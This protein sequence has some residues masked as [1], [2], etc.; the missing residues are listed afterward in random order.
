[1]TSVSTVSRGATE[2]RERIGHDV[3]EGMP[4]APE[5]RTTLLESRQPATE[6][7]M[8]LNPP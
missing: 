8:W 6:G 5:P 2:S 1:M 3:L 4:D 7:A